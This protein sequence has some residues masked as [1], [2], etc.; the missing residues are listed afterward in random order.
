MSSLSI[1]TIIL[2]SFIFLAGCA[3]SYKPINPPNIYYSNHDLQQGISFSY[4]YDVL[5]EKGNKKYARKEMNKSIRIVAVK[6]TNN[7]ENT[8]QIGED[9]AFYAGQSEVLLLEP[10]VMKN[11]LKQIAPAYLLYLPLSLLTL[12]VSTTTSN[13]SY[14]IGLLI[15]PGLTIG[16]MA[17]AGSANTNLLTELLRYNMINKKIASGETVYGLIG[18]ASREY[19]PLTLKFIQ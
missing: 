8:I 7:T 11:S 2:V 1:R 6:I 4:K 10:M 3:S 13:D 14:P 17:F 18:I 16:N 19:L 5:H 9:V 12:N 15:G